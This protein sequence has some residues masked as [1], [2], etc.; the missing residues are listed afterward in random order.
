MLADKELEKAVN[1]IISRLDEVNTLYISKVAAQ[2]KR[3][4]EL[5]QTSINR[6]LLMADMG[7]DIAEIN[8][9]L[10]LAT[11]LNI[12]DLFQVYQIALNDV[13]TDRRF[14]SFMVENP[15][16]QDSKDRLTHYAQS[17][18][19]QSA[20][21]ML[22][23]SNTTAVSTSYQEAIDKAVYA[24]STGATDYQSATREIVRSLGYN[25]MQVQYESGYHRRLDTAVRQNIIDATNQIAQNASIMMGGALGYDAIELSAHLRS[26][27]DHEPVQGRV[28]LKAEFD[29]MQTGASF[30][31]VD[32]N[33]YEGFNRP[34][35]EWNCMHIA[36]AFSTEHSVRR[37]S[38][39]QLAAW[40]S[41]NGKGCEIDGKHYSTYQA[42]QYMRQ[43][44]TEIRRQK[45][46]AVAAQKAGDSTLRQQCQ[47]KINA[48][49]AK[50][51]RVAQTS[52]ITPRR[53]RMT[54]EGFRAV[55][56]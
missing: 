13:Y 53:D 9:R 50:Y 54:V 27:P 24:V 44:E 31:D 48:L 55:K 42:G 36:M 30:V 56:V 19:V 8:Q 2:I 14:S 41:Q 17:V 26:A 47:Q 38:N 10:Q 20:R 4:G 7:A 12:K 49:S 3:I 46:V 28:F 15:L 39:E 29:K 6:L 40:K 51:S 23:I 33:S 11:G 43:I 22:N 45:D 1:R 37:V 5:N 52:G 16:P 21:T 35:G 34:I 18:A 25:G 32:G